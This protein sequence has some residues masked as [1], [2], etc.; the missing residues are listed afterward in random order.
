MDRSKQLQIEAAIIGVLLVGIVIGGGLST[1]SLPSYWNSTPNPETLNQQSFNSTAFA[2]VYNSTISYIAQAQYA[3]ASFYLSTIPLIAFPSALNSSVTNS[4]GE[5]SL[6]NTTIPLA[7][8][9]LDISQN[10]LNTG[11]IQNAS[12]SVSS[13]CNTVQQAKLAWFHFENVT[14]VTFSQNG[15]PVSLYSH[16]AKQIDA[17]IQNLEIKCSTITAQEQLVILY[18]GRYGTQVGAGAESGNNHSKLFFP[19]NSTRTS[20]PVGGSVIIRGSVILN[21]TSV[22]NQKLS[23]YVNGTLLGSTTTYSNGSFVL[24]LTMPLVYEP[25]LTVWAVAIV[26]PYLILVSNLL[27]F[28]IL[29]NQTQIIL[30]DYSIAG[31]SPIPHIA[32]NE[33]TSILDYWKIVSFSQFSKKVIVYP[34]GS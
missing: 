5:L 30:T 9:E 33:F 26:N 28:T 22:G 29:F 16:S 3:N 21:G 32:N 4:I 13:G 11:Q 7:A 14:T 20:I 12:F 8:S 17:L 25:H 15:V 10:L 27:N 34:K 18:Y 23:F 2:L 6:V 19:I 24:N 1:R 31:S